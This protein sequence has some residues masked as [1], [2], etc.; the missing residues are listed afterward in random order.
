MAT[1]NDLAGMWE[2]F[3]PAAAGLWSELNN[4]RA[5]DAFGDTANQVLQRSDPFGGERSTYAQMLKT[6]LTG[7]EGINSIPG[8]AGAQDEAVRRATRQAA[9]RGTIG[10]GTMA[11]DIAQQLQLLNLDA[12]QKQQ[13][14]LAGA[15]GAGM[16]PD[17]RAYNDLMQQQIAAQRNQGGSIFDG[18]SQALDLYK[19]AKRMGGFFGGS[20]NLSFPTNDFS[21]I[22][23]MVGD[24][25]SAFNGFGLGSGQF[26]QIGSF[27]TDG[28]GFGSAS[29]S[30]VSAGFDIGA[31]ALGGGSSSPFG[32][33]SNFSD[34]LA[35]GLSNNIAGLPSFSNIGSFL[36]SP[37]FAAVPLGLLAA[38]KFVQGL[39]PY[40]DAAGNPSQSPWNIGAMNRDGT[41][42]SWDVYSGNQEGLFSVGSYDRTGVYDGV[43]SDQMVLGS[44]DVGTQFADT[45]F[46]YVPSNDTRN[47][48]FSGY[49]VA[50]QM[51]DGLFT[52]YDPS[53]QQTVDSMMRGPVNEGAR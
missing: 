14:F 25:G 35:G 44:N 30:P 9:A 19:G 24:V 21:S 45:D 7:P 3:G 52:A 11:S 12:L 39:S 4:S 36:S 47:D 29:A 16:A 6:M 42:G 41:P 53:Q 34:D 40:R 43:G 20:P 10:T 50:G 27:L 37:G 28:F 49:T 31:S 38:T 8:F 32:F 51:Q 18:I 17:T 46:F 48:A 2:R 22:A 1:F 26:G 5:I 15:A 33:L 13:T 23:G